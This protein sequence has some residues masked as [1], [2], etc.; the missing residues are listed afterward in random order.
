M[1]ARSFVEV[2]FLVNE[3]KLIGKLFA[4]FRH[5]VRRGGWRSNLL[6]K[7]RHAFIAIADGFVPRHDVR[8]DD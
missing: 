5:C 8:V 1:I 6:Y 2:L 4:S 3:Y 7:W